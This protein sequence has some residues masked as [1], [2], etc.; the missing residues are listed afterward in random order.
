MASDLPNTSQKVTG[1][2][3]IP[4]GQKAATSDASRADHDSDKENCEHVL[5]QSTQDEAP[6]DAVTP[7]REQQSQEEEAINYK[8]ISRIDCVSF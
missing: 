3:E 7:S 5:T 6:G 1:E 8:T 2:T 4:A